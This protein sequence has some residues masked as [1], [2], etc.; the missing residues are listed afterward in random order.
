MLSG[1]DDTTIKFW[2]Y[3]TIKKQLTFL[4]S[5]SGHTSCVRVLAN[6]KNTNEAIL[7]SGGGLNQLFCWKF[8][9]D[10]DSFCNVATKKKKNKRLKVEIEG[11]YSEKSSSQQNSFNKYEQLFEDTNSEAFAHSRIMDLVV[12]DTVMGRWLIVAQSDSKLKV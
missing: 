10:S 8:L 4:Q 12:F 11:N 9:Y 1:S 2:S 3:S 5:L 6:I 7:F